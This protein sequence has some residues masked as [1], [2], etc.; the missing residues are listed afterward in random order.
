MIALQQLKL[1]YRAIGKY[2]FGTRCVGCHSRSRR[3]PKEPFVTE[4]HATFFPENAIEALLF[5]P[6]KLTSTAS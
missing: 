2:F 5:I 1:G 6:D 4:L 3:V